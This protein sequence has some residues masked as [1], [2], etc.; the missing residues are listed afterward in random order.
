M[1]MTIFLS[2]MHKLSETSPYFY[3]SYDVT[4]RTDLT[5]L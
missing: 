1:Q 3:E 2:I 4:G 5:A